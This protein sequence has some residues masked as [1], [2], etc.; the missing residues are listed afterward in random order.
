MDNPQDDNRLGTVIGNWDWQPKKLKEQFGQLTLFDVTIELCKESEMLNRIGARLHKSRDQ[1]IQI[2]VDLKF[3]GSSKPICWAH[4]RSLGGADIVLNESLLMLMRDIHS[5]WLKKN[6]KEGQKRHFFR[7]HI[8]FQQRKVNIMAK[9]KGGRSDK[10]AP[11][12]NLK[13]KRAAKEAKRKEKNQVSII[14]DE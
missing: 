2:L 3:V 6:P 8:L 11:A 9:D 10:K 1:V 4:R 5:G 7:T 14:K 13:E 12:K